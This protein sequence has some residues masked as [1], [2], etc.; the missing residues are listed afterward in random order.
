MLQWLL[1]HEGRT[2]GMGQWRILDTHYKTHNNV[3][4][5]RSNILVNV[6]PCYV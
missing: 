1:V 3:E 6:N 5:L 4:M 2:Y